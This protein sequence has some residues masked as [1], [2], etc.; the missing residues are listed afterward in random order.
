MGIIKLLLVST[1]WFLL[2]D[3]FKRKIETL[4][5]E[6]LEFLDKREKCKNQR[7]DWKEKE[8]EAG[9]IL[10]LEGCDRERDVG[11]RG[12]DKKE[13]RDKCNKWERKI[14]L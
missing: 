1:N 11:K 12:G 13:E 7:N 9:G 3:L 8:E 6:S 5:R 4:K 10:R 2:P 14:M